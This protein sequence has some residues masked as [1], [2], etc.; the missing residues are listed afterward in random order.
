M[1]NGESSAALMQEE[2]VDYQ[3]WS[4]HARRGS[5]ESSE[6]SG[7]D[8]ADIVIFASTLAGPDLTAECRQYRPEYNRRTPKSLRKRIEEEPSDGKASG[9][10]RALQH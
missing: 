2:H 5:K 10:C 4:H 1:Q 9:R 6:E 3:S 8:K 7:E